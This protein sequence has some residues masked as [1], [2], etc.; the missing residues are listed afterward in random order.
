MMQA[1]SAPIGKA[2]A[3]AE[4]SGIWNE[5]VTTGLRPLTIPFLWLSDCCPLRS[6]SFQTRGVSQA[7]GAAR[8]GHRYA[9]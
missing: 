9:V 3:N 4:D 5:V 2:S 6:L 8:C 1:Q 7:T